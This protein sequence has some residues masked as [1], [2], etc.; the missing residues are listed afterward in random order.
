MKNLKLQ[1]LQER[2]REI[3]GELKDLHDQT[4]RRATQIGKDLQTADDKNLQEKIL[5]VYVTTS[6]ILML[7]TKWLKNLPDFLEELRDVERIGNRR[8]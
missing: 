4:V 6:S 1:K 5:D 7:N 8:R 3:E 2:W